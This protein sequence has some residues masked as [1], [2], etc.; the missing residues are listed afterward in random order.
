MQLDLEKQ[1]GTTRATHQELH[2]QDSLSISTHSYI[3]DFEDMHKLGALTESMLHSNVLFIIPSPGHSLTSRKRQ[4]TFSK[5]KLFL[6]KGPM[7]LL[8]KHEIEMKHVNLL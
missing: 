1:N 7:I 2:L 8:T 4:P 6:I 5:E 3:E